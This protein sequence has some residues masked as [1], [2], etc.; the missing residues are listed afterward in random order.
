MKTTLSI[1]ILMCIFVLSTHA[2]E[3]DNLIFEITSE[4][5]T[6]VSVRA[7]AEALKA[8]SVVIPEKIDIDGKTFTVTELSSFG[9]YGCESLVDIQLPNTL[10]LLGQQCF[11]E[12]A[13]LKSVDIPNGCQL[14]SYVFNA[15]MKLERVHLPEDLTF[16]PEGTFAYCR[17]LTD[18]NIPAKLKT[19]SW[20]AFSGCWKLKDVKLP[21]TLTSIQKGAFKYCLSLGEISIPETVTTLMAEAFAGCVNLKKA[22][23]PSSITLINDAV[24]DSC[25]VLQ[26]IVIPEN[27]TVIRTAAFRDCKSLKTITIP[28]Q[29]SFIYQEAF[30]GCDALQR[31][32]C[33]PVVPPII[34]ER[35]FLDY[36]IP[37]TVPKG[38]EDQYSA[39]RNWS[40][41]AESPL[42]L[43][44]QD[45]VSNDAV[46]MK[47]IKGQ[48]I[49]LAIC[50]SDNW[51]VH[52]VTYNGE[53]ITRQLSSL[54]LRSYFKTPAI[55]SDAV[56]CIAYEQRSADGLG[57]ME[58]N[59]Q[60]RI[61][62]SNNQ[63]S[64]YDGSDSVEVYTLQGQHI[65]SQPTCE[66]KAR[67]T[68][69]AGQCYLI[70]TGKKTIK[71]LL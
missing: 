60:T 13:N 68:L 42:L 24:F 18:I 5:E 35:T 58:T 57:Q 30:A 67:F 61:T 16:L 54:T 15:C 32:V 44:I 14:E 45:A 41:F 29:V 63:I 26:E 6:T 51:Q 28:Q 4:E 10:K 34:C 56:L 47:V 31:I 22:N 62:V 2:Y 8:S 3:K 53:D 71:V 7:D 38:S 19:I 39:A 50:P 49:Q 37:L 48:T 1:L 43:T 33:Q 65:V 70:K 46:S 64:V 55:N 11:D 21:P 40:G 12:C 25:L 27:V 59:Q 20:Y 69:P 66:G 23:I 52:S 36:T 9:F 17:S